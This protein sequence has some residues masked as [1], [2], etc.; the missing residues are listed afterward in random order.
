MARQEGPILPRLRLRRRK[1][2]KFF[3][4]DQFILNISER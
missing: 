3:D 4:F 2:G 1:N